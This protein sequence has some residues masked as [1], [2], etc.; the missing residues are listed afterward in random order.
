M[1][2]E[3][4]QLS[5]TEI[6]QRL[7][8]G[9]L[10]SRAVVEALIKRYHD[11]NKKVGAFTY[12]DEA[13]VLAQ[14][15]TSDARR[16]AGKILGPLDGI[17][18][19]IKDNIAVKGQPLTCSSKMLAPLVSPYDAHVI[20]SLR[21]SGAILYGR[22]NMDEFAMGSSTENSAVQKTFNPWDLARIVEPKVGLA[23]THK[24]LPIAAH[25]RLRLDDFRQPKMIQ[26][27]QNGQPAQPA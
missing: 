23:A 20:E 12:L 4:Y 16:K 1:A 22:L 6:S 11:L 2:Q 10:T 13:D 15:D 8:K 21:A 19:G 3:I 25:V 26:H 5:A 7:A 17:P 24:L 18:V 9:E 14:A 27:L